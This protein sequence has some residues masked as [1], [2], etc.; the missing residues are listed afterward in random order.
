MWV[1]ISLMTPSRTHKSSPVLHLRVAAIGGRFEAQLRALQLQRPVLHTGR[2]HHFSKLMRGKP[3][4]S[5]RS[6]ISPSSRT[7]LLQLT[8]VTTLTCP[9]AALLTGMHAEL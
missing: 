6:E 3:R 1:V 9:S 2:A 5:A 8:Y 4:P 7:V